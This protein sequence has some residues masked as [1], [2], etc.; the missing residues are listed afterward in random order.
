MILY[1]ALGIH[2]PETQSVLSTPLGR[3]EKKTVGFEEGGGR[4]LSA[5]SLSQEHEYRSP[6]FPLLGFSSSPGQ[7]GDCSSRDGVSVIF[8]E[9]P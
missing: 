6:W 1:L 4:L 8:L 9:L 7:D 3:W 5:E 2:G